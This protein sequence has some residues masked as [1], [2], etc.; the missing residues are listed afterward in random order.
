MVKVD[1]SPN[2]LRADFAR[3]TIGKYVTYWF[4]FIVIRMS[5]LWIDQGESIAGIPDI[6]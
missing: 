3:I 6:F 1:I 2:R 5:R 4:D